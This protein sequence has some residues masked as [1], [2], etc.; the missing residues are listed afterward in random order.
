MTD[1]FISIEGIARRYPGAG[2]GTTTTTVFEDFWLSMT[3]GEFGC[4][5]AIPAAARPRC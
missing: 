5:I 1:K 3:R 4:V 2:G